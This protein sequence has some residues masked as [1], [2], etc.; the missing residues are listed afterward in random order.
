MFHI[1]DE[2]DK[3][4]PSLDFIRN[5][6]EGVT[7]SVLDFDGIQASSHLF[8]LV[9]HLTKI[10]LTP[11]QFH[12]IV[13]SVLAFFD[14]LP[15]FQHP[16]D[17][18]FNCFYDFL[19]AVGLT[20]REFKHL[21][22]VNKFCQFFLFYFNI[23]F[24]FLYFLEA[25]FNSC[26]EEIEFFSLEVQLHKFKILFEFLYFFFSFASFD[27]LGSIDFFF[28]FSSNKGDGFIFFH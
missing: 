20:F 23:L 11:F 15:Q 28:N 10:H 14:M 21:F 6:D 22:I 12:V 8:D 2:G 7:L 4:T 24:V 5:A 9:L 25:A 27:S 18:N 16:A 13:I 19:A 1:A 17:F 3:D 26:V